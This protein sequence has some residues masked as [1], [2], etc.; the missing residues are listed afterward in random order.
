VAALGVVAGIA[1]AGLLRARRRAGE[2][3]RGAAPPMVVGGALYVGGAAAILAKLHGHAD[4]RPF[5]WLGVGT[6]AVAAAARALRLAV[7]E[8]GRGGRALWAACCVMGV[9]AAAFL[10]LERT[11]AGYLEAFGL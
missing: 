10:A 7:P 8:M 5:V 9:L 3:L 4:P 11:D 6:L 1:G 2:A